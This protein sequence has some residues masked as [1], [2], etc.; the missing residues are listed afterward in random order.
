MLLRYEYLKNNNTRFICMCLIPLDNLMIYF[1][2]QM[3]FLKVK[4]ACK[5]R[6]PYDR[7]RPFTIV[8]IA[9]NCSVIQTIILKT[10]LSFCQRTPT[11]PATD[12]DHDRWERIRVYLCDRSDR[13]RSSAIAASKWKP[14]VQRFQRS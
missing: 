10:K 8:G 11:I 14:P 7:W 1:P 12:N 9:S 2:S 13:D 3:M 5:V 6:F 4:H